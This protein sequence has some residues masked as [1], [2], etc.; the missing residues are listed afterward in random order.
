[1]PN[2]Y[3]LKYIK[4]KYDDILIESSIELSEEDKKLIVAE[5]E[6]LLRIKKKIKI[7][8]DYYLD[9][10]GKEDNEKAK[11]YKKEKK[12]KMTKAKENIMNFLMIIS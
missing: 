11:N 7:E 5:N 6:M 4:E 9:E 2:Y 12:P 3:S 8:D 1:M 10:E